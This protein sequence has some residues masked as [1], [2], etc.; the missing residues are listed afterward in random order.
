MPLVL[1]GLSGLVVGVTLVALV[2]RINGGKANSATVTIFLFVTTVVFVVVTGLI[3]GVVWVLYPPLP[4]HPFVIA[5]WSKATIFFGVLI[6]T[7]IFCGRFVLG[8]DDI[9]LTDE[10]VRDLR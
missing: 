2:L 6:T 8:D 7:W 1:S 5:H 4:E 10:E 9:M 3:V